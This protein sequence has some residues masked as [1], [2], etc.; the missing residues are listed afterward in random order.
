[1]A[2]DQGVSC[3]SVYYTTLWRSVA[4]SASGRVALL[5]AMS[6]TCACL[7]LW[8]ANAAAALPVKGASP[9]NPV[10][11]APGTFVPGDYADKPNTAGIPDAAAMMAKQYDLTIGEA[12]ARLEAQA[13]G[14]GLE[15]RVRELLG[16]RF[17]GI[18][19]NA[20]EH[21]FEVW[22]G[23]DGTD[24]DVSAVRELLASRDLPTVDAVKVGTPRPGVDPTGGK[25]V[26][27]TAC[28]TQWCDP[29]FIAGVR[30][31]TAYGD[32]TAA[33]TATA[34]WGYY[35]M[36]AGHCMSPGTGDST[37]HPSG[38]TGS[39]GC[40]GFGL[41]IAGYN[42]SGD[43]DGGVVGINNTGWLNYPAVH[44][45]GWTWPTMAVAGGGSSVV[46]AYY[47]HT[48]WSTSA[49]MCG[50]AMAGPSGGTCTPLTVDYSGASGTLGAG[51]LINHPC[52]V[53]YDGMCARAGDSGGPVFDPSTIVGVGVMVAARATSS[54]L[55]ACWSEGPEYAW[56]EPVTSISG[57]YGLPVNHY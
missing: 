17:N 42:A 19:F 10:K 33:F 28:N 41:D 9:T 24:T 48:G 8:L 50:Y 40:G 29:P 13:K 35:N 6:I 45:I 52:L 30:Y 5:G 54:R 32:C 27:A 34:A 25:P 21:R 20:P 39:T 1:M 12:T 36:T 16:E 23:S 4:R 7:G 11:I 43:G 2:I 49:T 55:A 37:C 53:A 14:F 38:T 26:P 56:A 47:C 31:Y 15:E 46:G 51:L 18:R 44:V 3:V 57:R 22:V